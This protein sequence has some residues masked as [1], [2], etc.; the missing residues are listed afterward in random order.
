MVGVEL[1]GFRA[2]LSRMLKMS[3]G[4]VRVVR[5][6]FVIAGLVVRRSLVVVVGRKLMMLGGVTVLLPSLR[7]HTGLLR[8]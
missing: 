5:S 4:Q 6:S 7:R 3:E 1:C 8:C 2:M